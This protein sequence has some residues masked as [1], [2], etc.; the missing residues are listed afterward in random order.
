MYNQVLAVYM[1][2]KIGKHLPAI[3]N[4]G[5]QLCFAQW[6]KFTY[7][8]RGQPADDPMR[9]F[10]D[11]NLNLPDLKPNDTAEKTDD[12]QRWRL[13]LPQADGNLQH[14]MGDSTGVRQDSEMNAEAPVEGK[15][16]LLCT[17]SVQ[18]MSSN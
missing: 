6:E 18:N 2:V 10:K 15:I 7:S 9:H 12:I 13:D 3:S 14:P 4:D 11:D 8:P 16:Q 1:P 5:C 17:A